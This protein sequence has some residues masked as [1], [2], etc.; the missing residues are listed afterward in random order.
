MTD[1]IFLS[2][3]KHDH[4]DHSVMN[5]IT[6]RPS[7]SQRIECWFYSPEKTSLVVFHEY[8]DGCPAF[9]YTETSFCSPPNNE[10]KYT[11]YVGSPHLVL[12]F[13]VHFSSPWIMAFQMFVAF[14]LCTELSVSDIPP[15]PRCPVWSERSIFC[16]SRFALVPT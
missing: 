5:G 10:R 15:P 7:A 16:F 1:V 4:S 6:Q 11:F 9:F 8:S 14:M 3:S 2:C 12:M 13:W